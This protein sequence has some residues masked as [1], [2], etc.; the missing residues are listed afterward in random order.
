MGISL[1]YYAVFLIFGFFAM[2]AVFAPLVKKFEKSGKMAFSMQPILYVFFIYCLGAVGAYF[3]SDNRDFVSI[4]DFARII[5]P[6]V[7]V[8]L[9]YVSALLF[10]EKTSS[11]V[12]VLSVALCVFLQTLDAK[13]VPF[14]LNEIVFKVLATIF[15]SGFC[16]GYKV[17]NVL[18]HTIVIISSTMLFGVSFLAGIG[19]APVYLALVSAILIGSLVAYMGVNLQQVKIEFDDTACMLLAFMMANIFLLD[20]GEMSFCSCI[21]FTLVFW[22]EL[23]IALYN[24]FFINKS[25]RLVFNSHIFAAAQKLPLITLMSNVFKLGLIAVFFGWFQLFS[26]NQYSLLIVTYVIILWLNTSMGANLLQAP[27]S[28]KQINAEFVEDIKQ[29]LKE[30]KD[31]ISQA[32]N[33]KDK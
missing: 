26:V 2:Y 15:F 16:L 11:V 22:A 14:G 25:E 12:L 33:K 10:G 3:L 28:L 20:A 18:P 1:F 23:S 17:L 4:P 30:T 7:C 31:T 5:A 29:N 13:A 9:I 21:I 6:L 27:K 8:V 24:K 32:T 19:A